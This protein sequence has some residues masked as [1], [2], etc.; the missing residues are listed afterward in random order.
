MKLDVKFYYVRWLPRFAGIC[1]APKLILIRKDQ[2]GNERLH[3]HELI[4]AVQQMTEGLLRFWW[5]YL[6]P[7]HRL[8]YEVDAYRRSSGQDWYVASY[9]AAIANLLVNSYYVGKSYREVLELLTAT[10]EA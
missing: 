4:H 3:R 8:R 2:A 10:V 7:S 5:R 6:F 1:I 9:R